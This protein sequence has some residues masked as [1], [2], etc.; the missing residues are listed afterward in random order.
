MAK[1]GGTPSAREAEL[2]AE[3]VRLRR[4]LA[5]LRLAIEQAARLIWVEPVEA[6][7]LLARALD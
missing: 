2:E 5:A 4:E 3:I 6:E 1:A 7:R